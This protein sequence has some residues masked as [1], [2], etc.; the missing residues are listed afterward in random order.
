MRNKYFFCLTSYCYCKHSHFLYSITY[1]ELLPEWQG[2][3]SP[4]CLQLYGVVTHRSGVSEVY[5]SSLILHH[6][7]LSLTLSHQ[8]ACRNHGHTY[9]G[10]NTN[11]GKQSIVQNIM[12][13]TNTLSNAFHYT[14]CCPKLTEFQKYKD[15]MYTYSKQ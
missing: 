6:T 4:I 3:A 12:W 13:T 14:L 10:Q 8:P 9:T 1:L 5:F 15:C 11:N 2:R 7:P